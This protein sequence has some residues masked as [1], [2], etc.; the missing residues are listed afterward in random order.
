MFHKSVGRSNFIS[1][2]SPDY[3]QAGHPQQQP[4][5]NRMLILVYL[6]NPFLWFAI[7]KKKNNKK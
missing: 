3:I 2:P 1:L 6:K 7:A 4:E 5:V